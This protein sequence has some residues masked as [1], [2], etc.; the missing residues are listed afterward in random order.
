MTPVRLDRPELV[1]ATRGELGDAPVRAGVAEAVREHLGVWPDEN[2]E[3]A[4]A[5]VTRFLAADALG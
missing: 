3:Q 4:E 1:G 5:L 2:P